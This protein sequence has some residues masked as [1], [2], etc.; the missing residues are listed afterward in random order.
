MLATSEFNGCGY[1]MAAHSTVAEKMA[2]VPEDIVNALRDGR[3]PDDAKA[4]AL[5]RFA[6][7]ALEHRGWIPEDEQQA[8]ASCSLTATDGL[9]K[10]KQ[11]LNKLSLLSWFLREL[12]YCF[13][14]RSKEFRQSP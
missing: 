10:K 4:R 5:V 3:E 8:S 1:C 7:S 11:I 9:L 13:A 14:L 2:G 12:K 6:K